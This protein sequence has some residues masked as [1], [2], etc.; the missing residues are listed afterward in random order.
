MQRPLAAALAFLAAACAAPMAQGETLAD[1][2]PAATV[3]ALLLSK[4]QKCWDGDYDSRVDSYTNNVAEVSGDPASGR[5]TI[6]FVKY[7]GHA[8]SKSGGTTFAEIAVAPEG[9]GT[10]IEVRHAHARWIRLADEV[11]LWLAGGTRCFVHMRPY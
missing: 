3:A 9:A 1:R 5:A 4:A 6:R 2:R 11:R 8:P 10:R 7:R